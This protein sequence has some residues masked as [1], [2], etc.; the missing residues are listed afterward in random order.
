MF[1]DVL[2]LVKSEGLDVDIVTYGVLALGCKNK[3][4]AKNLIQ[5]IAN[6]G[7]RYVLI[8]NVFQ[9]CFYLF[10]FFIQF[11]RKCRNVRYNVGTSMLSL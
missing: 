6:T 9:C 2:N 4:E 8:I 1:Q 5:I 10:I 3:K 11:K 7:F